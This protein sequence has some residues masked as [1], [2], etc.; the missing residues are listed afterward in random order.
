[1]SETSISTYVFPK[2]VKNNLFVPFD[3]STKRRDEKNDKQKPQEE[4]L[5]IALLYNGISITFTSSIETYKD[6]MQSSDLILFS[7]LL[8]YKIKNKLTIPKPL[9]TKTVN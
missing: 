9:E 2:C 4:R 6:Y 5:L 1:M 3:C 7:T 8:N